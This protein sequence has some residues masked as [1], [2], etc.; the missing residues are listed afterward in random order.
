MD[1]MNPDFDHDGI[2]DRPGGIHDVGGQI[3]ELLPE[4]DRENRRRGARK[5][6]DGPSTLT[7]WPISSLLAAKGFA[8]IESSSLSLVASLVDSALDLLCTAII[9]TTNRL[10]AWRL[11]GLERRFPVGRRRL[12]PLGIL[13]FSLI[14]IIS[15]VQILQESVAKLYKGFSGNS[16]E[17]TTPPPVA[18]GAMAATVLVKGH[19]LVQ[20]HSSTDHASAGIGARL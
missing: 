5:G 13:V 20:L 3:E 2:I 18:I 1:S 10:V 15:F 7:S 12:E 17:A 19:H 11:Q 9:W 14:M 8:S 6:Q 16:T 4:E